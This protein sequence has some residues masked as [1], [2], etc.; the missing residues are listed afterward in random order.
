MNIVWN[1]LITYYYTHRLGIFPTIIK[2]VSFFFFCNRWSWS[3]RIRVWVVLN[4]NGTSLPHPFFARLRDH[5][6]KWSRKILRAR[7]GGWMTA[8]KKCLQAQKGSCT[9][10]FKEIGTACTIPVQAQAR[11]KVTAQ[12]AR[13]LEV[14][15]LARHYWQL[16]A[17]GRG[18]AHFLWVWPLVG[19]LH[20]SGRLHIQE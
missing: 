6:R 11:I 13:G 19:C 17:A 7:W 10:K 14:P 8:R 2:E 20:S 16:I 9:S 18:K 15:P 5:C 4:I 3:K 1:R 12:R